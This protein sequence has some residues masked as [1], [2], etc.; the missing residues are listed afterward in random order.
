MFE[1]SLGVMPFAL[2]ALMPAAYFLTRQFRRFVAWA[3]RNSPPQERG[4]VIAA[5]L[6]VL[7]F[8]VGGFLQPAYEQAL[9]CSAYSQ[10]IVQ[11]VATNL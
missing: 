5:V 6:A 1:F 4:L 7:G 3:G 9:A 11:C 10:P 2:A 8:V